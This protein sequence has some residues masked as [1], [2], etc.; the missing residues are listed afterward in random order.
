[1]WETSVRRWP[2]T[3]KARDVLGWEAEIGVR[4]GI[5]QMVDWYTAARRG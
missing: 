2:S 5:A 3:A 1:M 4:E